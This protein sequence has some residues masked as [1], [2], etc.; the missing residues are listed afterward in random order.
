MPIDEIF[1]PFQ[2][3]RGAAPRV[4]HIRSTLIA[5]SIR[6]I[7]VR[8]KGADYAARLD[9]QYRET[10]LSSIAAEWLTIEAGI[11]HYTAC[12]ALGFSV[13]EAVQIG[14]DVGGRIQGTFLG[15]MVRAAKGVGVTPWVALGNSR[16]LYDRL[17]Q[18][19]DIG[20]VKIGPK[21]ARVE[22]VGQP[23]CP[24]VYWRAGFRGVYQ[25]ALG[26]FCTKAYVT[27]VPRA[28]TATSMAMRAAWA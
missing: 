22:I 19:G 12:D 15:T 2:Y 18:G 21:E 11:A 9:P 4:S 5:S 17:F 20:V 24:N 23:L 3:A 10:V 27:D 26:L 14:T 16:K 8:G 7:E 28:L 6:S 13:A 1:V 25:A